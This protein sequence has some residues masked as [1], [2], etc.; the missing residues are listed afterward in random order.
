MLAVRDQGPIDSI[1]DSAGMLKR[2]W[3]ENVIGQAGM[4]LVFGLL[5]VG[6]FIV[7]AA[8]IVLVAQ[9][10]SGVLSVGM[11]LLVGVAFL[12]AFLVQSA[13]SGVYSAALFRY[14]DKGYASTGFDNSALQGAFEPKN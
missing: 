1:K 12:L 10:G 11:V 7:G 6:M 4:S 14:A 8:L 9:T 5:F 13:L 2:T 3:G